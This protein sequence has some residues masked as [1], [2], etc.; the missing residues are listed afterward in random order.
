MKKILIVLSI[1]LG[2]GFLWLLSNIYFTRQMANDESIPLSDEFVKGVQLPK[3]ALIVVAHDDDYVEGAATVAQLTKEGYEIGLL[4][5]FNQGD[6]EVQLI[7]IEETKEAGRILNLKQIDYVKTDI[8]KK[9]REKLWMPIPYAEFN[10]YYDIN[11]L[12]SNIYESI[13]KYQPSII[14][15]LDDEIGGYGHPEHVLVGKAVREVCREMRVKGDS[16]VKA[17]AQI[18]F[19]DEREIAINTG[20]PVYEEAKVIYGVEGMPTPNLAREVKEEIEIKIRAM[21]A[22]ASQHRNIK[23]FFP[24]YHLYPSSVYGWMYPKEYFRVLKLEDF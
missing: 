13:E 2:I 17:I 23:K 21:K 15:T 3:K 18:V 11:I 16:S 7:R 24:N 20:K 9:T 4:C 10:E 1:L 12:K 8:T 14:F 6:K 19:C 22:H 5:V